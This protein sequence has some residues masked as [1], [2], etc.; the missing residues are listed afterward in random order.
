MGH[1][2]AFQ[3]REGAKLLYIGH[4]SR[5][6]EPISTTLQRPGSTT[7]QAGDVPGQATFGFRGQLGVFGP[8][9]RPVIKEEAKG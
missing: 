7:I 1:M 9:S 2:E 8:F 5:G 6:R 3:N 4:S